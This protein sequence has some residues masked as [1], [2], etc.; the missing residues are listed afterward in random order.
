MSWEDVTHLNSLILVRDLFNPFHTEELVLRKHWLAGRSQQGRLSCS[1]LTP[2]HPELPLQ[3][4]WP[5]SFDL[6][7]WSSCGPANSPCHFVQ[8]VTTALST[9]GVFPE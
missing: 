5:D 8:D 7:A 1:V 9:P 6:P 2:V 4:H 3:P